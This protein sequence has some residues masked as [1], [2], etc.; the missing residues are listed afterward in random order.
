MVVN[1]MGVI[2]QK[3]VVWPEILG[4]LAYPNGNPC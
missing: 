1:S 2:E 3:V 4:F